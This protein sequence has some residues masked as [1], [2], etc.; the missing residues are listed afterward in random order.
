MASEGITITITGHPVAKGRG[1]SFARPGGGIGTYTPAKTRRWEDDARMVARQEMRG[2]KI[3]EGCLV[4]GIVASLAVPQSWPAWKRE[5]ALEGLIGP[6][7]RP[8][9]SN[10]IKAI[11]DALN[12]IVWLD[13]SQIVGMEVCKEYSDAPS[14]YIKV[15]E[16][17]ALPARTAK[18]SQLERSG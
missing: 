12:G 17:P 3:F 18:R 13:D 10:Y 15:D 1:R 8:D 2:R 11:E 5:A 6:S 16:H 9:L 14:V 4:V 7:S